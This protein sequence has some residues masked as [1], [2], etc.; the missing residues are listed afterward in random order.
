VRGWDNLILAFRP[1]CETGKRIIF[2]PSPI[3]I[4]ITT[5]ILI[6]FSMTLK[7]TARHI[8]NSNA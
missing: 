5:R 8:F 3:C 1:A 4:D 2:F 7:I 6:T